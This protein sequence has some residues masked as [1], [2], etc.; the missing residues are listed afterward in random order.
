MISAS[1]PVGLECQRW[2]VC[3]AAP[4]RV[5]PRLRNESNRTGFS[6]KRSVLHTITKQPD[7]NMDDKRNTCMPVSVFV[8]VRACVCLSVVCLF[9]CFLFWSFLGGFKEKGQHLT[10]S[11][12]SAHILK[13]WSTKGGNLLQEKLWSILITEKKK[14]RNK[15]RS[16]KTLWKKKIKRGGKDRALFLCT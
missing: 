14:E 5:G 10:S 8:C 1:A 9:L 7:L 2:V 15:K 16:L 13:S 11:D 3:F 12:F 4:G 6:W